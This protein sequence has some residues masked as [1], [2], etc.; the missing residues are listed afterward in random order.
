M[1]IIKLEF[2][3][4]RNKA[5]ISHQLSEAAIKETELKFAQDVLNVKSF[6]DSSSMFAE[7]I[8]IL[9]IITSTVRSFYSFYMMYIK[10]NNFRFDP[11][12]F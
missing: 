12:V 4:F 2:T 5:I 9:T 3:I 11:V 10:T 7:K 8:C 6:W 1:K